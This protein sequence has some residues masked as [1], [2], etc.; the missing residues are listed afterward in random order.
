VRHIELMLG[1]NPPASDLD[2]LL[3]SLHNVFHQVSGGTPLSPPRSLHGRSP[4]DLTN[5]TSIYT[6]ELRKALPQPPPATE[7]MGMTGYGPTSFHD[8][9]SDD[10]L[11]SEGSSISDLPPLGYPGGPWEQVWRIRMHA[12]V[13]LP[14]RPTTPPTGLPC[15]S[16]P[17][18]GG[19]VSHD[20]PYEWVEHNN[21]IMTWRA[22]LHHGGMTGHNVEDET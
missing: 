16:L 12:G 4:F 22:G 21:V 8:L 20:R 11:L 18:R 9:F 15:P 5:A 7:F 6:R 13:N 10:D 17:Q 19:T 14:Y 3:F 1:A 2:L